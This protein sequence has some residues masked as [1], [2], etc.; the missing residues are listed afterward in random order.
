MRLLTTHTERN[1]EPRKLATPK[2]HLVSKCGQVN[3][4][5]PGIT[6]NPANLT[7]YA[8][9]AYMEYTLC[10]PTIAANEH[11]SRSDSILIK[12]GTTPDKLEDTTT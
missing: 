8:L 12:M 6:L 5:P 10:S 9:S 4:P 3:A 2:F 7:K 11:T 1:V